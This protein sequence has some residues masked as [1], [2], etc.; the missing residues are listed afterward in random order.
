MIEIPDEFRN[1]A[2]VV[3]KCLPEVIRGNKPLEKP[4]GFQVVAENRK[5]K[6]LDDI[7]EIKKADISNIWIAKEDTFSM[8]WGV[9]DI[10]CSNSISSSA[11]GANG[12]IMFK[13]GDWKLSSF[14][15]YW[16]CHL[17]DRIAV[18]DIKESVKSPMNEIIVQILSD[19]ERERGYEKIDLSA[20]EKQISKQLEDLFIEKHLALEQFSIDDTIGYATD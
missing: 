11:F 16:N 2:L 14:I 17:M 15:T 19:H 5:T 4:T 1:P 9:C 12:E 6:T 10:P 13:V 3:L 8:L 18:R 20:C 7:E